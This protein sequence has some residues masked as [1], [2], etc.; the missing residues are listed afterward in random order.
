MHFDRGWFFEDIFLLK[1]SKL[2][3]PI[4]KNET[5]EILYLHLATIVYSNDNLKTVPWSKHK[6]A[7]HLLARYY[8]NY[9]RSGSR[10]VVQNGENVKIPEKR[11]VVHHKAPICY[12]VAVS[13]IFQTKFEC[14]NI[15]RSN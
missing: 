14:L 2:V 9:F 7:G 5:R 3:S 1:L 11:L 15:C 4:V 12:H 6:R 8:T 10:I 13:R